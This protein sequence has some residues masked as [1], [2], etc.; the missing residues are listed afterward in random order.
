MKLI[1]D[2]YAAT[3]EIRVG[4]D[5]TRRSHI[6]AFTAHAMA[7]DRKRALEAGMDD[8]LA[9][10]V[11]LRELRALLAHHDKRSK[12]DEDREVVDIGAGRARAK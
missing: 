6:V 11:G 5:P 2:G 9:K 8:F 12:G 7:S 4:E 10:P 3:R 1:V